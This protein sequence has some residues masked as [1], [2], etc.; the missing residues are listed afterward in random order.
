MNAHRRV[1]GGLAALTL[2]V[3]G[4]AACGSSAQSDDPSSVA[5]AVMKAVADSDCKKVHELYPTA[6]EQSEYPAEGCTNEIDG[7]RAV[8]DYNCVAE[9]EQTGTQAKYKCTSSA[10]TSTFFGVN[11]EKATDGWV[12][13]DI[14][15]VPA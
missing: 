8:G 10:D 14:L 12:V 3:G 13:T 4:L 2:L 9:G 7:S 6:S 1:L 15:G 11:L 5:V